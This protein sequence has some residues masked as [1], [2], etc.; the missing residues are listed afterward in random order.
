[1]DKEIKREGGVVVEGGS[2][3]KEVRNKDKKEKQVAVHI[4]SASNF[5]TRQPLLLLL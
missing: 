1:M 2:Y 5:L 3:R 4:F